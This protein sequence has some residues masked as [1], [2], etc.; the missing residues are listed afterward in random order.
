MGAKVGGG[1]NKVRGLNISSVFLRPNSAMEW[2]RT[3]V[4]EMRI[5]A[6]CGTFLMARRGYQVNVLPEVISGTLREEFFRQS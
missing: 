1:V 3:A 2:L 4:T 5:S 6:V